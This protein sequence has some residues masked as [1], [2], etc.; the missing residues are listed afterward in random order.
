MKND[1]EGVHDHLLSLL[2]VSRASAV[3]DVGCGR[4]KHLQMLA[5]QVS[6]STRLV[7]I[8]SSGDAIEA[9]RAATKG[10]PRFSFLVHDLVEGIPFEDGAFDRVLSVNVIEAI[11]DKNALLNEVRRVLRPSGRTVV[12]HFDW[13]SQLYDGVDKALIRRVVHAFADWK[14]KWMVDA[15][16][17]MGRRLWRTFQQAGH[18]TGY[19]DA[20]VHMSTFFEPGQYGWERSQDFRS[21]VKRGMI[22]AEEYDRF[23]HSLEDLASRNEYFYAITMFSYVGTRLSRTTANDSR[24]AF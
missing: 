14:Q 18:F 15:D 6:K 7:G 1:S 11:P 22:T 4:G 12:S 9:A 8:D 5:R 13:D 23:V 3:L 10:D 17:W 2:D 21:M 20:Y 24:R 16:G 19:M